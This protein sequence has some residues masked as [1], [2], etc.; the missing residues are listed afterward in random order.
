MTQDKKLY[1]VERCV[2]FG[3]RTLYL[4]VSRVDVFPLLSSERYCVHSSVEIQSEGFAYTC[5]NNIEHVS[6]QGWGISLTV[7]PLLPQAAN[8]FLSTSAWLLSFTGDS[9]FRK[10]QCSL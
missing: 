10:G 4:T 8:V 9:F 7:S 1:G 6:L 5:E 2:V 3:T